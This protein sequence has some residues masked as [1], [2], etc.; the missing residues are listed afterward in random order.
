M[1]YRPIDD[2]VNEIRSLGARYVILTDDNLGA[3]PE[4]ARELFAALK[5]LNILWGGQIGIEIINHPDVLQL[6]AQSGCRFLGVGVESLV[7]GNL[8]D[9]H[10]GQ[11]TRYPIEDV[12]QAFRKAG[13]AMVASMIFGMDHDTP[14]SLRQ[15]VDRL[16]CSGVDFMLPWVLC[17]GPG[18]EVYD[19]LK[20]EGRLLHENYNFYN[21]LDVVFQP[22]HMSAAQLAAASRDA[23]QR[24]YQIRH[25]PSRVAR[26]GHPLD[27]F[28]LSMFFWN[29]TRRGL[30]P[31]S[32]VL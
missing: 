29:M 14:E 31:F 6:A 23:L 9:M 3:N 30:H 4:R 24:F 28:G 5:P 7:P 25:M 11:G 13:I 20:Q 27:V 17:P 32:G 12:A 26:A 8:H 19:Q 2:V 18:C 22:K 1:R 15:T 16:L 10:K 21:G